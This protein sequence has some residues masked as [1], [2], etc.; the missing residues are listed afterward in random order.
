MYTPAWIFPRAEQIQPPVAEALAA[1]DPPQTIS[2]EVSLC[3]ATPETEE[4]EDAGSQGR[5]TRTGR[6]WEKKRAFP[7][8]GPP[9]SPPLLGD[10]AGT[11]SGAGRRA[12]APGDPTVRR[13][14]SV[15]SGA[16]VCARGLPYCTSTP[17]DLPSMASLMSLRIPP[18]PLLLLY[19]LLPY[20]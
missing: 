16:G 2:G 13:V 3:V 1:C 4:G 18:Y 11:Q 6:G 7:G 10:Y 17:P 5:E 9:A 20:G 12:G 8:M 14:S 19:Q 15:E